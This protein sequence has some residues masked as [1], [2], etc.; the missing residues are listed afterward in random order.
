MCAYSIFIAIECRCYR[1]QG[2]FRQKAADRARHQMIFNSLTAQMLLPLMSIAGCVAFAF[3]FLGIVQSTWLQRLVILV[4]FCFFFRFFLFLENKSPEA[5]TL[6]VISLAFQCGSM[7]ALG[8]PLVNL[9][10]LRPYRK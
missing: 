1:I 7:L 3:D 2:N 4:F 6:V 9:Y 10:F 8:A 5:M